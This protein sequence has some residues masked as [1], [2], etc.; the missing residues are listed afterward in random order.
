VIDREFDAAQHSGEEEAWLGATGQ[1]PT[2]CPACAGRRLSPT[3]LA[4]RF[5]GRSIAAFTAE[6]WPHWRAGAHD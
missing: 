1:A 3:A 4:L 5:D 6:P 2:T